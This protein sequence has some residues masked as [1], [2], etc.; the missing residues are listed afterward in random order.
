MV[1]ASWT[2]RAGDIGRPADESKTAFVGHAAGADRAVSRGQSH[3]GRHREG[4][5]KEQ[6]TL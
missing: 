6:E 4:D 1:A 3:E 5:Q 2:D